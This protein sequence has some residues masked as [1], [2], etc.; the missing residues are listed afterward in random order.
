MSWSRID[1]SRRAVRWLLP[2]AA[3]ALV[4]KCL[5]CLAAYLGLGAALGVSGPEFCGA[6]RDTFPIWMGF[7]LAFGV[8]VSAV[9]A[10]RTRRRVGSADTKSLDALSVKK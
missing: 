9:S 2:T 10:W 3:L 7:V 1:S 4:P 8:F 5:L 6:P